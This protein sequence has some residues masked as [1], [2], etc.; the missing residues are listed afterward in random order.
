[1]FRSLYDAHVGCSNGPGQAGL[2]HASKKL[3]A[4]LPSPRQ[5]AQGH[6]TLP[7]ERHLAVEVL[8]KPEQLVPAHYYTVSYQVKENLMECL[9]LA[10]MY[11]QESQPVGQPREKSWPRLPPNWHREQHRDLST[12]QD[13]HAAGKAMPSRPGCSKG[14]FS[15]HRNYTEQQVR[16]S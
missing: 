14:R 13:S 9:S 7:C 6:I 3:P 15:E 5:Q 12:D 10:G 8:Q 11:R 16:G 4:F 2:G 1:M